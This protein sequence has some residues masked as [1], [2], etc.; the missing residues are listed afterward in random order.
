[1]SNKKRV[2][3]VVLI[4]MIF[5][6][7]SFVSAGFIKD[8]FTFGDDSDLEGELPDSKDFDVSITMSNA[9][10]V[11]LSWE[12]PIDGV[13]PFEPTSGLQ[14]AVTFEVTMEDDNGWADLS[15]GVMSVDFS[16]VGEATRSSISCIARGSGVGKELI[17][18]CTVPMQFYDATGDDWI[19]TVTADD[20]SDPATNSPK[21]T[22]TGDLAN[23]P[24][25]TYAS[26]LYISLTDSDAMPTPPILV[27]GGVT[28]STTDDDADNNI[29]VKNDGNV[30]IDAAGSSWIKVTGKDLIQNPAGNGDVIE[31]DSFSVDETATPC[32]PAGI[33]G[34]GF[35]HQLDQLEIT[36]VEV[37]SA[38]LVRGAS[39]T[40]DLYFCI[41]AMNPTSGA[42]VS[43]ATY[44]TGVSKWIIEGTE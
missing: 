10:P 18:D 2:L 39:S 36:P 43:S 33:G 11:I 13:T 20:G 3:G 16:K 26:L 44:E 30:D 21:A 19:I 15:D 31:P 1:M 28:A 29:V 25:F 35:G 8:L 5:V 24:Y 41:E 7:V 14:T 38:D 32:D 42:A 17:F 22:D 9:P 4:S 37:D 6:S 23:Y 40:R 27:W 34:V 12:E